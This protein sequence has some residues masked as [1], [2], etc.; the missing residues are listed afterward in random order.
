MNAPKQS[1]INKLFAVSSNQCAFPGCISMIFTL[2]DKALGEICHIK[3]QN[4]GGPRYDKNQSEEDRHSFGNLI[5]L[6]RNHHR[7]VDS[8]PKLYTIER[9]TE[10]KLAHEDRGVVEIDQGDARLARTLL[11]DYIRIE[12][13]DD[14]QVMVNSPNSTQI[15]N[16]YTR[17]PK[18]E[19]VLERAEGA[20]TPAESKLVRSWVES[21]V[22]STVRMHRSAAFGMWWKRLG[23]RFAV[24]KYE[25]LKSEQMPE[26]EDWYRQQKAILAYEMR[27][28]AP[29]D[30]RRA[31]YSAIK[32]AMG[33][34]QV[35][36]TAYYRE[37]AVRLKMKKPFASLK[38][39]SK[40]NLE[41]VYRMVLADARDTGV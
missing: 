3:A 22:D 30:Y 11:Q 27:T 2:T 35:E 13:K 6:C 16:V 19:V 34:L 15:K 10:M 32:A 17:P 40:V 26:V 21:L 29:D 31:R 24:A 14:A 9:L 5:L 4:P 38:E 23:N 20:I 41:R 18:I 39:L 25:Q 7:E 8:D 36:K 12:A 37:L 1:T 33:K 28:P